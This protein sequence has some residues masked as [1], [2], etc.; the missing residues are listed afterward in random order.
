M[1]EPTSF[2]MR[3]TLFELPPITEL[4]E[5]GQA[6]A[7]AVNSKVVP[8]MEK[9]NDSSL[10]NWEVVRRSK[11]VVLSSTAPVADL[12]RLKASVAIRRSVVP[13]S[14]IPAVEDRM[15]VEVP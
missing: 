1:L 7:F 3:Y 12:Y 15:E 6:C 4:S 9:N 5:R 14:T 2:T 8:P 10:E 11:P 13:V